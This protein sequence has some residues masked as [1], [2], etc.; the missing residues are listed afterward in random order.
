L[1]YLKTKLLTV[2]NQENAHQSPDPF[3]LFGVGS[4]NET[5]GIHAYST[6]ILIVY[7]RICFVVGMRQAG[8]YVTPFFVVGGVCII[9]AVP[10]FLLTSKVPCEYDTI[11]IVLHQ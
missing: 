11:A 1:V 8:G 7:N 2:H 9:F 5:N 4:W 3:L 6:M 10:L